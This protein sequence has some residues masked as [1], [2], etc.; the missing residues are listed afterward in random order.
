MLLLGSA[1]SV[2]EIYKWYDE[3]G[4]LHFSDQKPEH[5]KSETVEIQPNVEGYKAAYADMPEPQR[6]TLTMYMTEWCGFCKKARKYF[7]E[8][9]IAYLEKNI[10][11]NPQAK[12]EHKALGGGGIPVITLN[13][14]KM[15]GFSASR[16]ESFYQGALIK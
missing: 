8:N 13:G 7:Q 16:F 15:R 9:N 6:N 4:K 2:A 12:R 1:A 3:S 14:K 5:L 10:E 11:K